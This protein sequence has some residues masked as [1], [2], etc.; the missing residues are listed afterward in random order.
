MALS[1]AIALWS[2][3]PCHANDTPSDAP[4]NPEEEVLPNI[5]AS[6]YSVKIVRKSTSGKVYLFELETTDVLPKTGRIFLLKRDASSVMAFRVL[7]IYPQNKT[8]A[9]KRVRRYGKNKSLES[10]E[11]FL[12]VEKESDLAPPAPTRQDQS[13][14]H[15]L[16]KKEQTFSETKPDSKSQKDSQKDLKEEPKENLKVLP[17]DPELDTP[18]SPPPSDKTKDKEDPSVIH[19]LDETSKDTEETESPSV[20]SVEEPQLIDHYRHWL[21]AGLGYVINMAPPSTGGYYPFTSGN[22]RYGYTLGKTLFFS[23][24]KMQDSI[25]LEGGFF[26]Y[27][28]INFATA[29][30]SYTITSLS[31]TLRYNIQFSES[32]GIFLYGGMLYGY[33]VASAQGQSSVIAALSTLL[34]AAGAG[35]LLQIGP[36]WYTRLDMGFDNIGLSLVLRF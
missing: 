26:L 27:K 29:N 32:F 28:A 36:G 5:E 31:A 12:A 11:T 35:L 9:A 20:I 19:A 21:T 16:E 7:K 6:T 1:I 4:P 8:Y 34:P 33:V 23:Q 2:I 15:E 14:L 13:D 22:F 18:T 24:P 10:G 17:F 3:L 25:A 30:D